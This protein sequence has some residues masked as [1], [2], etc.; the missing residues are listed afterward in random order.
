A[1]DT[2]IKF[3]DD[4]NM[5]TKYTLGLRG[6]AD[7]KLDLGDLGIITVTG[8]KLNV[9]TTLD[10]LQGLADVKFVNVITLLT[11]SDR[12]GAI[13]LVSINNPSKLTLKIGDLSLRA[14]VNYTEAGA[15]GIS[16]LSGLTLVPGNNDVIATTLLNGNSEVGQY[17]FSRFTQPFSTDLYLMPFSGSSKNP[18]LDAG[19]QR[20]RQMLVLPPFLE[21]VS[22]AKP[23][24][25]DWYM[26][27]PASAAEDGIVQVSTSVGNPFFSANL[28]VVTVDASTVDPFVIPTTLLMGLPLQSTISGF[29]PL[30]PS[31]YSLKGG[32]T[33]QITFNWKFMPNPDDFFEDYVPYWYN[34]S[35]AAG[36]KVGFQH[37]MTA[38]ARIGTSLEDTQQYWYSDYINGHLDDS[39]VF[40]PGA[41]MNLHIGADFTIL[42]QYYAKIKNPPPAPVAPPT[43]VSS[44]ASPSASPATTTVS[45]PPVTPTAGTTD[46][47]P[48]SPVPTSASPSPSPVSPSPVSPSPIAPSP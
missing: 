29:K 15:G 27:V 11:T 16:T 26:T 12:L 5:E 8:I 20:L 38:V 24:A 45:V 33:K 34:E 36:G 46:P 14:G 37:T 23:Y 7:S 18:A 1:H 47:A 13:V 42:S 25:N 41:P 2:Y 48:T 10:G 35:T 44:V 43:S 39:G 30:E 17:L 32:E 21:G 22:S 9:K 19:L 6:T 3:I 31:A 40:I 4:L 28:D